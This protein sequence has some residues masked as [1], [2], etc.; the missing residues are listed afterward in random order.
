MAYRRLLI[1]DANVIRFWQASQLARPMM[2]GV[3]LKSVSCMDTFES[4]LADV[5]DELDYVLV[6]VLTS[7]L[8]EEATPTT[9][10][11][12]CSNVVQA[13]VKR[14]GVS[15]KKSSRVEVRLFF[16]AVLF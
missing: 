4:A 3:P 1:G 12:S 15:A 13:I 16:F 14:I 5:T 9:L 8:L 7:L 6:S 10:F 11:D 2:L